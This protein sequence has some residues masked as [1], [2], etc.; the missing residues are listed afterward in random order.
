MNLGV[1]VISNTTGIKVVRATKET[2]VFISIN[3]VKN[4]PLGIDTS[5]PFLNHMIETLSWR[6]NLNIGVKIDTNVDLEHAIAEDIGISLGVTIFELFKTKLPDGIE[7]FGSGKGIIDEAFAEAIISIEGRINYYINGPE[8]Q[9]VDGISGYSLVAF[10]E[11]FCQGCKCTLR[12]DYNGKDPHHS[13]E[14]AFRAFGYAIKNV[15]NKNQWRK[16]TI[17]A[18]KGTLD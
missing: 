12:L 4:K 14:A 13:W 6:A 1:D 3:T 16:D 7:G 5:I 10:L 15:F 18:L 11:G 9:N 8:F 17:S 2:K